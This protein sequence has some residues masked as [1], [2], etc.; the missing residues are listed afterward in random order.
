LS[1]NE[2]KG[3]RIVRIIWNALAAIVIVVLLMLANASRY[4]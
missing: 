1:S 2:Q 4:Q 3:E